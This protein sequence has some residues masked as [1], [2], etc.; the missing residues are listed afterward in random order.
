M[1]A[2]VDVFVGEAV[3]VGVSVNV[4]V[5]VGVFVGVLVGVEVAVGVGKAG[6]SAGPISCTFI[7]KISSSLAINLKR[8]KPGSSGIRLSS[9]FTSRTKRSGFC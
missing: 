7:L 3:F 6:A 1:L 2:G 5:F 8:S 4:G 9:G